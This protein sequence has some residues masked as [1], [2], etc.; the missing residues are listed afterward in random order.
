MAIEWQVLG[1][2][3][4]DNALF[5]T[6]DSGQSRESLLF[7]CG[8]GCLHDLRPSTIQSVS[9]LFLSHF[10]MDHVSGF[11]TFFRLNYNRP[12]GPVQVWGPPGTI[13]LMWHRFNGFIWNLHNNQPGEWVVREISDHQVE[14]ARFFTREAFGTIHRQAEQALESAVVYRTP[15]WHLETK[16]L[17]HGTISSLACRIVE[18][19]K[20]NIDPGKMQSL[21]LIPGPWLKGLTDGAVPDS[22]GIE[23]GDRS[24]TFGE[25]R[26]QLLRTTPGESLAYLT[27][28][29]IE[30]GTHEWQ[31]LVAWLSGTTILVCECQYRSDDTA[32]AV[33]NGHMTAGLVGRLAAEARVG[34]LVL[35]HLSRRYQRDEWLAMRDQAKAA[36]PRTELP[37]EWSIPD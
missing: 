31:D 27:D 23:M 5:I 34:K 11:D 15:G 10:H 17:P 29:R 22:L 26:E 21:G 18:S 36:F 28:F 24:F 32:L 14:T 35:Q 30:P 33:Q 7:D 12:D 2:A 19:P 16:L 20:K 3:G 6:V 4:A 13:D 8:E 25:M 1:K 9:H 37:L